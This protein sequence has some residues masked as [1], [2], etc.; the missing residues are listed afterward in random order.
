MLFSVTRILNHAVR[1]REL[2]FDAR[3]IFLSWPRPHP[4]PRPSAF[5]QKGM[6]ASSRGSK[7]KLDLAWLLVTII[8]L[9]LSTDMIQV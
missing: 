7:C 8:E 6:K 9:K 4:K 3:D 2:S 1:A 5:V